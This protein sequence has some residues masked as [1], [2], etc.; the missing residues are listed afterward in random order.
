[1]IS[2]IRA[3]IVVYFSV[4]GRAKYMLARHTNIHSTQVMA[5]LAI[6]IKDCLRCVQFAGFA[7][8][9]MH[10]RGM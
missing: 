6:I 7:K 1:M 4:E 2:A 10:A 8:W 9:F 3:G 5:L